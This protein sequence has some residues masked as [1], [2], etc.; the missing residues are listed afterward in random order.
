MLWYKM[1]TFK[2]FIVYNVYKKYI[3]SKYKDIF[4]LRIEDCRTI[5]KVIDNEVII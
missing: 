2:C 4:R 3:S 1:L 5:F